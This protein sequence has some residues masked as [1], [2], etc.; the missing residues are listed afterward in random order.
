MK[1]RIILFVEGPDSDRFWP[2]SVSRPPYFLRC[3]EILL[4]EKWVH[5]LQPAGV[6]FFCRKELTGIVGKRTGE[7]V[8]VVKDLRDAEVWILD[9]RWIIETEGEFNPELYPTECSFRHEEKT[10]GIRFDGG[11]KHIPDIIREW[12]AGPRKQ[13]PDIDLPAVEIIGDYIDFLWDIV[14]F[15]AGQIRRDF[16]VHTAAGPTQWPAD[17][18]HE[19]AVI[20]RPEGVWIG[21]G[22][23]V[24]PLAV[25]DAR[26]GPIIVGREAK[27]NPHAYIEGPAVVGDGAQ[28]YS[29]KIRGGTTIGP[30]C[31]IGGEVEASVFLGY[32]NKYH[33]GFF[34]HGVVG[35]WVNLGAMTTNSDLK[36]NY[37]PVRAAMPGGDVET[38]RIKV[39][40]FLA[41]HTK[42]GIGTL[43][44]TGGAVGFAGNVFGGG[45]VA[46]KLV[47][48]F[49]W[50]GGGRFVEYR[51][52]EAKQTAAEMCRRR[53]VE[54]DERDAQL[55]DFIFEQTKKQRD[56]F[57]RG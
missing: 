51:L 40:S 20:Q 44:P 50:G 30:Q 4:W 26:K 37:R 24:G 35:E 39:G 57:L 18:V 9:G 23:E 48:E 6:Y 32:A 56:T 29:G 25:L 45:E 34:G 33:D 49:T 21:K 1:K 17:T 43:L 7:A 19:T 11:N 8:N 2:L 10:V 41:D 22:A 46:P 54:F 28:I 42:T 31:R 36:N 55:F 13:Y 53:N 3:G 52:A 47:P 12:L 15:N 5:R 38:G 16:V 14:D 27:I